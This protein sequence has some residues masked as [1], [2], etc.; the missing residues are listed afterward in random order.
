MFKTEL[1]GPAATAGEA[2]EG[3]MLTVRKCSVVFI[4]IRNS[5]DG[6][7]SGIAPCFTSPDSVRQVNGVGVDV[8]GTGLGVKVIV[9]VGVSVAGIAVW[10]G[11]SSF[12]VEQAESVIRS[13]ILLIKRIA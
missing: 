12:D 1:Y 5:C 2:A 3:T 13:K 9:G 8:A 4:Y 7:V 6:M 11:V 10:V